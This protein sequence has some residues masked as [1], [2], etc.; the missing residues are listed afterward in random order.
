MDS[1]I[2]RY[3]VKPGKDDDSVSPYL[4]RPLRLFEEAQREQAQGEKRPD[5]RKVPTTSVTRD[6]ADKVNP[7]DPSDR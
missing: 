6:P 2:A 3:T 5:R 4:R 7:D 1:M